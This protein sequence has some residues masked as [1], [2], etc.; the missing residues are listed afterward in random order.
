MSLC[1]VSI[2]HRHAYPPP[3][4]RCDI[5]GDLA[6]RRVKIFF[7]FSLYIIGIFVIFSS[8]A[9]HRGHPTAKCHPRWQPTKRL[10]ISCGLG[11]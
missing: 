6:L 1:R 4:N 11:T 7:I 10:A 3:P 5:F 9:P 8:V 2:V